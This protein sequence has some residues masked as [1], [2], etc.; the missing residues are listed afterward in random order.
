MHPYLHVATPERASSAPY[1][2]T[3]T[4]L[5]QRRTSRAPKLNT[6]IL[7]RLLACS[8]PLALRASMPRRRYTCGAAPRAPYLHT[9]TSLLLQHASRAPCLH[10]CT[11]LHLQ[12]TSRAPY[13]HTSMPH[14]ATPTARVQRAEASKALEARGRRKGRG[15]MEVWKH[16]G[17]GT[18]CRCSDVEAWR[19]GGMELWSRAVGVATWRYGGRKVW[20]AGGLLQACRREG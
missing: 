19:Y 4:S 8:S 14:L 5:R 10:A 11:S 18:Q 2:Y 6:S 20:N 7:P 9:S 16:G 1:L 13:L 17:L 3:F 15:G 12:H